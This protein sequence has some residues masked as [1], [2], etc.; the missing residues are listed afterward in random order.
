MITL[1]KPQLLAVLAQG[2]DAVE[3]SGDVSQF[4]TLI[5]LLDTVAHRFPIVTP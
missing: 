2:P 4:T 1:T 3:H 5:G